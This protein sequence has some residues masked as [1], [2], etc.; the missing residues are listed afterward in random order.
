VTG[1]LPS[2]KSRALGKEA[3]CR[4]SA[5][6]KVSTRRRGTLGKDP[7]YAARQK[8]TAQPLP[9][10]NVSRVPVVSTRQTYILCRVPR[11]GTRQRPS[12]PSAMGDTRQIFIIIIFNSKFFLWALYSTLKHMFQFETFL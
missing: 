10:V 12:L 1:A 7:L 5:L 8:L 3:V 9:A 2:A 4:V 11:L 6:G